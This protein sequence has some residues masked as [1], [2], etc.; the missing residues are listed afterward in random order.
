MN[1]IFHYFKMTRPLNVILSGVSVLIAAYLMHNNDYQLIYATSIV[2]ML[3]CAFANIIN[4]LFDINTD[5]INKPKNYPFN[6]YTLNIYQKKYSSFLIFILLLILIPLLIAHNYFDKNSIIYLYIIFFLIIIY[7]PCLKGTPLI[8]NIIISHIVSSV[9]IIT[10][11]ILENSFCKILFYPIILTFMLTF[12]RELAKDIDDI[13]GDKSAGL[14][15]FPVLFGIKYAKYVLTILT[16]VL[17]IVSIYPYYL[18]IYPNQYLFLL[19]LL[20]H[21]PLI[22]C[23]F[24]LWKYPDFQTS[25]VLTISTKY[26]TIGGII[27]ILSTKLLG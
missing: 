15:T 27:T 10:E 4:D 5:K 9:F 1:Y 2:V 23:I 12:I 8:G 24:Y 21:I 11:L 25:R 22:S 17:I 6:F 20:V 7:T 3:F 13:K 16:T 26:I 14:K 18:N 19:V